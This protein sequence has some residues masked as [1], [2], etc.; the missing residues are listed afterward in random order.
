MKNYMSAPPKILSPENRTALCNMV[1]RI[2]VEAGALILEY[3]DGVKDMETVL[4]GDGSPVTLADQEAEALIEKRL[5]NILPDIPVVGEE[6]FSKGTRIN[7]AQHDYFWLVDPLDGTRAFVAGEPEFT[8]NIG[9]IHKNEPVL[10]VIYAPEKG[11]LYAGYNDNNGAGKALRYFED[12]DTEKEI[13]TRKMPKQGL[14]ILSSKHHRNVQ[15]QEKMLEHVKVNK[16]MGCSSSLKLCLI[17]NGKADLYPRLG[18]T[19]EWDT[20]AGHAILRAAGGDIR[21]MNGKALR[22]GGTHPKLLN[23]DFIA[24]SDDVFDSRFW[25]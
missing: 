25:D 5:L 10:G 17:A 18:P 9:L 8:V 22:Y 23:P 16:M 19:C 12:S 11:E 20:A 15:Q 7:F 6:S 2:A 4:K 3:F 24:A 14:T 21:D 1:R 13:R